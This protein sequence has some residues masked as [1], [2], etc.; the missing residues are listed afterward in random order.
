MSVYQEILNWSSSRPLFVQDA[1]R[2][3][4]TSTTLTQT[5]IDELVELVKKDCGEATITL[6]SI[7]LDN[8][9][10]PAIITTS[11]NYPKLIGL[12]N[13][14]NIGALH[15]QGNLQFPNTGLSV[16][17]GNNGSGKSS[18]SRILRKLCWSRSPNITLK[19]NVFN[20]ST[21]QQQV[22]F[23]LEDNGS[24]INFTWTENS[25]SNPI[26]NSIFVFDNDCGDI[27]IN[28]ENPTEYKPVGIDVLEKLISTFGSI[29]QT[30][31][32]LVA[33][34]NTQKPTLPQNL[35]Q[36]I[37]SQWYG[38]IENLQRANVDSYIQ[39]SQTEI[40]RKQELTN[41]TTA[42][43]PQLNITNL[44]N[45]RTRIN[46]YIQ[47]FLQIEALFNEQNI[48][49]IR[50][51]RNTFGSV[52]QAYQIAT[53]EL[54]NVNTLE[55]FGTNPWRTLWEAARN[56]AHSS[57][58]S[59]GQNFP[60]LVSLEKCV[61]CQQELDE[62][63]QQRLS[64][65]N[66]FVLN[67]VSTQLNSINST[68]Q[69]KLNLYNS[70][71]VP[72]IENFAELEQLNPNF[73]D[74]Y[75]QFSNSIATLR[76][77]VTTFLQNGGE[78]NLSLQTLT[79][80]ITSLIPI[81]DARIEQNN[82]LLQ[83][84][85]GLVSEL[86]ELTTKEFLFN[87]KTTILKYFDEYHYKSWISRCQSQ[88]TTNTISRKIGELMENQAVSLQHQEFISHL[89]FFNRDLASKVLISRT[90][91]SQGN[92]FQKCGLNGI[93]D[94]INVIL[95]EGE[96]KIIALSNFLAECTIDNRLNTI[97]F[98]DPVTSLDMDYRELIANKFVQ[99]SENRQ[100]VVFT[101]DLS[102]LRLLIDTHKANTTTDCTII[103][104]DKYNGI[105]G[106]VTDEIP[107]LAKNV[108]E[109][110][111]SIR[112]I[113]NEHDTLTLTDAHGRETKLDSAR[114]RFRMLLERSVE[115]VLSNKT[116][117]RFSKNIHLKKGNL[118]S[119][120]VTEKSDVDFLLNLFGRY[121]ITEHDG[122]TS[123]IP[124]L[125]SKVE[126]EQDITDYSNW[127][128][129]FKTKQRTFQTTNAYS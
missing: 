35:I 1:L 42:Q 108:Q 53:A 116:Y 62:T 66:Q 3:I 31:G 44:T 51:Y 104:I 26:L 40:E 9:H 69:Q 87:N 30:F 112:R 8:T 90:R 118:S 71:V 119:Y 86:N 47:Q 76:N 115:E 73:R 19:K 5:D 10:I 16:I 48:N 97:I 89:N 23:I 85:N 29:H 65:F 81:I 38:T 67:D 25:P 127:K 129:D 22:D 95:S 114:K 107:Y 6:N 78:L 79:P 59:D 123:T 37:T 54:Q 57:N 77:L 50:E 17:Y 101:H 111:D 99:L 82:Q 34:Y 56:Y 55:G 43:N 60:S 91:T 27:Y 12:N 100:I 45:Q 39:F 11:G 84:R 72:S 126:I 70:L 63:A 117:E 96:Q 24:N 106:I 94:S 80:S 52:N 83:N 128:N 61:L 41:L 93:T 28:N 32:S 102:F 64:T 21:N 18:Y 105:S 33:S 120:I 88:L 74:N 7:P 20:Q 92:T 125:R 68:I 4:I 124:Q 15:N 13:P 14:I 110:V 75:N 49:E 121:S 103:G 98:D 109:R 36:T 58:L 2:R 122:G 46:G 113:L